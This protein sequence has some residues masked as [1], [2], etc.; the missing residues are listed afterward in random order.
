M[1]LDFEAWRAV[2]EPFYEVYPKWPVERAGADVEATVAGELL[3]SRVS[4][5]EQIL[6]HE[7]LSR[8]SVCHEYLLFER[9]RSGGGFGEVTK[10]R[11]SDTSR[12]ASAWPRP[13]ASLGLQRQRRRPPRPRPCSQR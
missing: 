6:I 13:R 3:L 8:R 11:F 12:S 10:T 4:T 9:F 5:A 7:P 2:A 1:S